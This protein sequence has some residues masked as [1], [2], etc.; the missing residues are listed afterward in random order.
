[1]ASSYFKNFPT[2]SYS[3]TLATNILKKIKIDSRIRDKTSVFYPY[4]LLDGERPDTIAEN[5]YEDSNFAWLIY[6]ANEIIDPYFEWPLSNDELQE[7]IKSKYQ[8]LQRAMDTIVFFRNNWH[9]DETIITRGA[10]ESL[11]GSLKKYWQ[12]IFDY[13]G[14]ISS[15]ERAKKDM[16]VE[17]NMV[18]ML[19]HNGNL[20]FEIGDIVK[21]GSSASGIVRSRS[22]GSV[23]VEKIQGLFANTIATNYDET[24]SATITSSSIIAKAIP[25]NEAVYWTP[26]TA[27]DYEEEINE[28]RKTIYILDKRYLDQIEMEMKGLLI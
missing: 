17:T 12:P 8:S 21:Q 3:G 28:Q 18:V 6:F 24:S 15:Y 25:D 27:F 19:N 2:V 1:M 9:P 14:E 13:R 23:V 20:P 5:Y 10:F 22:P 4:T 7:F 26:V 16:V 11:P